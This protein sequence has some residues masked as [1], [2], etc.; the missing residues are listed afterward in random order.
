[1]AKIRLKT[2]IRA[3]MEDCFDAARSIDLHVAASGGLRERAIAG[4]TS[5]LIGPGEEVTWEVF[6][7][8]L[9]QQLTSRITAFDRPRMFSDEMQRGPFKKW[10]HSHLFAVKPE[11]TLMVDD[12][13][14][15]APF[16]LL[17]RIVDGIFLKRYITKVLTAHNAAVKKAAET[18]SFR[19]L[20]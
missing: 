2:L 11:G 14:Y 17:G 1:M 8:G 15:S 7:L 12:V 3:P 6:P 4:V 10:R 9:R 13:D 20:I 16:W 19:K 18:G 5:G